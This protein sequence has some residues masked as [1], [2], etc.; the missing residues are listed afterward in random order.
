MKINIELSEGEKVTLWSVGFPIFVAL[1]FFLV[2]WAV[3]SVRTGIIAGI[4]MGL[5]YGVRIAALWLSCANK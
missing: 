2:G 3:S 4:V 5:F 1:M